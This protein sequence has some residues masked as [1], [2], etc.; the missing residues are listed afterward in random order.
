M[1]NG[2]TAAF[3][4]VLSTCP[5]RAVVFGGGPSR[6]DCWAAFDGVDANVGTRTVACT[7]GDPS[8]DTDGA[9]DGVCRFRVRGCVDV[10]GVP[11]CAPARIRRLRVRAIP[12]AARPRHGFR[13]R[14][15]HAGEACGQLTTIRVPVRWDE[16]GRVKLEMAAFTA[17]GR[18]DY[19]QLVLQC[20]PPSICDPCGCP[21][22]NPAGGPDQLDLSTAES[23]TDL[24]NGWT[25]IS[26]NFPTPP[27]PG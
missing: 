8:C 15:P 14:L 5:A 4:V 17:D 7:D 26:H 3:A 24:D 27:R 20:L 11:T 2:I 9:A 22:A 23:G 25:G 18:R 13:P 19:D 12:K 1:R 16:P 21:T 10:P 6:T